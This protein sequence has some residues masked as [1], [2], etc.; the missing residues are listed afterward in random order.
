MLIAAVL[1]SA[2]ATGQENYFV[3]YDQHLEEPGN[4][5]VSINPLIGKPPGGNAFVGSWME[6]EYGATG[7]WTMEFYLDGQST[8]RESTLFTGY[9]WENRFRPL[10][11]EH[12]INPVFYVEFENV[13]GSDKIL[14]DVVGFDSREDFGE[15]N[16]ETHGEREREIETKLILGSQYRGWNISENFIAAKSF[17]NEPWEFG[18][19]LGV[20][21]PLGLA[22]T[23]RP[24]VFCRENFHAGLELYG[25]LGDAHSLT[26][27]GTSHYLAPV[28][29]WEL[30]NGTAMRISPT[31][32]ITGQSFPFLVRVGVSYEV[33]GFG[34]QV[35]RM[36]R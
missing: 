9:R 19:A 15:P 4:L 1:L 20:S 34:R 35:R 11:G 25:G 24:C 21:R 28:L 14:K 33:A 16:A 27:R 5:E 22:A 26:L 3:T 8:R 10:A 7:W 29:A 31:F 12:W 32:G 13:H 17:S 30:A 18:Y 36:F 2:R 23:P 6:F